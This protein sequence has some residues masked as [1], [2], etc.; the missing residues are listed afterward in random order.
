MRA[1]FMATLAM[2]TTTSMASADDGPAVIIAKGDSGDSTYAP[3]FQ[4]A[5]QAWRAAATQ[6]GARITTIG[7]APVTPST[8]PDRDR[9]H[10]AISKEL[11]HETGLLW[12]ILLGHGTDDGR[13]ARFN[14]R[15]PDLAASDLA[16]WLKTTRRPLVII[17]TTAASASFIK[18]LAAP[19]RII[20][21]ATR[22]GRERSATRF[23]ALM[24][25]AITDPGADLDKDGQTSLLEAFVAAAKRADLAFSSAGLIP[26]EHAL[27]DDNGDGQGTPVADLA[28]KSADG[29]RAR[30]IHLSPSTPERA[31]SAE[32]RKR[33]DD[34]EQRITDLRARRDSLAEADYYAR[35]EPLL[36]SLARLMTTK[37]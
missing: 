36:L 26:S 16:D 3:T 1:A 11:S 22:N 24:P 13:T 20:I 7:D 10:D 29:A 37:P 5:A 2:L 21:T 14:L 17:D 25:L 15:G 6:A 27:L 30:Q 33:R 35:L 18:P 28:A 34:L 12:I 32:K 8:A 4:A 9:L 23:N 31:L 19:N